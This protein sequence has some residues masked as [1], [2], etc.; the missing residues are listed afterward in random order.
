[1][2]RD[3]QRRTAQQ[4]DRRTAQR[5][6]QKERGDKDGRKPMREKKN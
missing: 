4:K 5:N 2:Q 1:M 6:R 3:K